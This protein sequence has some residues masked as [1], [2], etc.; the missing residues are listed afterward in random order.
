MGICESQFLWPLAHYMSPAYK[1]AEETKR[2]GGIWREA[3]IWRLVSYGCLYLL[4][5]GG[6]CLTLKL[7]DKGVTKV[8]QR[9]SSEPLGEQFLVFAEQIRNL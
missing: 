2:E 3:F 4:H 7:S 8:L 9:A 5:E 6:W 1:E